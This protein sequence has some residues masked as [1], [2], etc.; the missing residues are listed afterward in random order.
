MSPGRP[1]NISWHTLMWMGLHIYPFKVREGDKHGTPIPGWV[2]YLCQLDGQTVSM[3]KHGGCR[4]RHSL[5]KCA[6]PRDRD[7]DIAA[8]L[9]H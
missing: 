7:L 1:L 8:S 3:V 5:V 2:G 9:A 6:N 4:R